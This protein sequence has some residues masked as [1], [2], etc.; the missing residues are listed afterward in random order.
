MQKGI[1]VG[2]IGCGLLIFVGLTSL[3]ATAQRDTIRTQVDLVVVPTTVR[4]N[5][6]KFVYGM[7]RDDFSIYEDGKLQEVN[8]FSVAPAPLSVAVVIDTGIGGS[9]LRRFAD[10]ILSLSSAFTDIDEAEAYRY[11]QDISKISDFTRSQDA[12]EKSLATIRSL[13]EGKSDRNTNP[14]LILPGRGP[15][16]LR[17]LLDRG[18]QPRVLNDA[19][20]RA[21]LDL[22]ERA[23]E[24]RRVIVVISDG[25]VAGK[26]VHSLQETRDRLAQNQIQTYGVTV[27]MAL[28]EGSTSILH[29]YA[30]LTG[31]DVYG[32]RTQD[33]MEAAFF[34]IMEQARHQYVLGYVSNNETSGL[35][36]VTRKIEVKARTGLSVF[37]RK[38]YLQY[39]QPR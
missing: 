4:D 9:A 26:T 33:A 23:P 6:G 19:L 30:D 2:L 11:D 3:N 16:W 13:A 10:S 18:A 24:N 12:L 14:W 1:T 34:R 27:G 39:P 36:P 22:E 5:A 37:H 38:S 28:L 7:E 25:Q 32:V 17:W 21:A 15:R 35:L 29:S 20:F 8:Q 31:G